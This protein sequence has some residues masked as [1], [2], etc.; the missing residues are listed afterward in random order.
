MRTKGVGK[1][2]TKNRMI[3]RTALAVQ[4]SL[5]DWAKQREETAENKIIRPFD[6]T[7]LSFPIERTDS[8]DGQATYAHDIHKDAYFRSFKRSMLGTT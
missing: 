8:D 3:C 4:Q 2:R 5:G 7:Y 1:A 6:N